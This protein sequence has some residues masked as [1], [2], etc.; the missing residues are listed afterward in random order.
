MLVSALFTGLTV[1]LTGCTEPLD[2]PEP[3]NPDQAIPDEPPMLVSAEEAALYIGHSGAAFIDARPKKLFLKGHAPGAVS[4]EWTEFR[5][6]EAPL[7]TGKLD[8]DL[9]RLAGLFASRGVGREHWAII[10]GDPLSLWGEEGRIAWT[11]LY[12]GATKVSIVDG[13]Y[14]AWE[15]A[16]LP[17]QKGDVKREPA[18]FEAEVVDEFIARK[19]DVQAFSADRDSWSTVIV[20]VREPGEYR[21]APDAPAYGALRAGHVPGAVNLPWRT[22]L[23]DAGKVLPPE[24][25][26]PVL[27]DKGIRPDA[28]IIT[29]CTGGVRSAHTWFVL[30]SLSYPAVQNYAASWWEWSLDRKLGAEIGGQRP[31]PLGPAWPPPSDEERAAA[32]QLAS[33]VE[34]AAAKGERMAITTEGLQKLLASDDDDSAELAEDP[35]PLPEDASQAAKA[36][37]RLKQ[38]LSDDDDSA[39]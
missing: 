2:Y 32:A 31:I 33:E 39:E 29:Y 20:D 38:L 17:T 23:D 28:R 10:F 34:A 11:L 8:A 16:G 30:H 3:A 25:L 18:V 26:G 4:A 21:G 22:L 13:G 12:L 24:K 14:A 6:Q 7:M 19:R 5:D 35:T 15:A 9:D 27:L 37:A 1:T 36:K